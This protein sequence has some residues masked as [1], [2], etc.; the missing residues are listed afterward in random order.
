MIC[1][2]QQMLALRHY[3]GPNETQCGSGLARECGVS[4][5]I[6]LTEPPHSRASPLPHL[7]C[8]D[9]RKVIISCW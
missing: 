2:D 7:D 8:A 4:A 3:R 1:R 5:S 6:S 9:L